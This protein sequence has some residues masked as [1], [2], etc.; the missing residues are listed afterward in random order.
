LGDIRQYW[1]MKIQ[2][3]L[4]VAEGDYT[5]FEGR[6]DEC[7]PIPRCGDRVQYDAKSV[8]I[9]G[10]QYLYGDAGLEVQLLA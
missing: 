7:P 2:I 5:L 3:V 8:W 6:A 9:Q 10:I 4:C 1:G